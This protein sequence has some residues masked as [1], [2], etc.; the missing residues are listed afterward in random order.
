MTLNYLKI[1]SMKG[2]LLNSELAWSSLNGFFFQGPL[3]SLVNKEI[4]F[5]LRSETLVKLVEQQRVSEW[6]TC[7]LAH[8]TDR[9]LSDLTTQTKTKQITHL[10]HLLGTV[11]VQWK[12][13]ACGSKSP[14]LIHKKAETARSQKRISH[15]QTAAKQHDMLR[16]KSAV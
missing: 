7:S 13:Q 12:Q 11:R 2:K 16:C 4:C 10:Q 3:T 14:S 6:W 9:R 1:D 8:K 5:L 15:H